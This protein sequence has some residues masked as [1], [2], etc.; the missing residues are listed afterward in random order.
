MHKDVHG[1]RVIYFTINHDFQALRDYITLQRFAG[2]HSALCDT[3]LQHSLIPL[4]NVRIVKFN[5]PLFL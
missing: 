5:I 3:Q 2:L 1:T 4:L